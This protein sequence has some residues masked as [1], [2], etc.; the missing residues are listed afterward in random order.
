MGAA[1]QRMT[2]FASITVTLLT[3]GK[4]IARKCDTSECNV[5][6]SIMAG[7]LRELADELDEIARKAAA[8]EAGTVAAPVVGEA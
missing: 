3:D 4:H 7:V 1:G 5:D 2:P 6:P 8:Q